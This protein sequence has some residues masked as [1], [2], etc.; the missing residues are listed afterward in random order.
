MKPEP[1]VDWPYWRSAIKSG[2]VTFLIGAGISADEPSCLPLAAGLNAHLTKPIGDGVPVSSETARAASE[3]RIVPRIVWTHR[4]PNRPV[5]WRRYPSGARFIRVSA[6]RRFARSL[7]VEYAH[8]RVWF[9][10]QQ[11]R[12]GQD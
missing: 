3:V 1:A 10:E 11:G 5:A 9:L 8:E 6:A 4:T 7:S 2:D 12:H